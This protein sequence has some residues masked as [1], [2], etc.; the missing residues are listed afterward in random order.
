MLV[1]KN[2]QDKNGQT[3]PLVTTSLEPLTITPAVVF[4]QCCFQPV[5]ILYCFA[6]VYFSN[7]RYLQDTG[8]HDCH[9][10]VCWQST[11]KAAPEKQYRSRTLLI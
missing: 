5:F 11:L 6:K 2:D 10:E 8:E 1:W 4:L 9:T 7:I 3:V